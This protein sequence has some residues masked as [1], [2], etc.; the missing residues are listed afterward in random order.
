MAAILLIVLSSAFGGHPC[1]LV[2]RV[3]GLTFARGLMRYGFVVLLHFF[4]VFAEFAKA[5]F[6]LVLSDQVKSAVN[7]SLNSIHYRLDSSIL[8]KIF[9]IFFD[10]SLKG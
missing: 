4:A 7:L 6:M 10:I 9:P 3:V 5:G 8:R 2:S 1:P